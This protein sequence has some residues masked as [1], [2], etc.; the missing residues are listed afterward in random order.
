MA[1]SYLNNQNISNNIISRKKNYKYKEKHNF[2]N[3]DI[4]DSYSSCDNDINETIDNRINDSFS[5]SGI[6]E[7]PQQNKVIDHLKKFK[8]EKKN[9][10][11]NNKGNNNKI[12]RFKKQP[13]NKPK[14]INLTVK[15][16]NFNRK[17]SGKIVSLPRKT[18]QVLSGIKKIPDS[19][20]YNRSISGDKVASRYTQSRFS[21]YSE[22]NQ[23]NFN[24]KI[25]IPGFAMHNSLLNRSINNKN[26][27]VNHYSPIH[28]AKVVKLKGIENEKN[29]EIINIPNKKFYNSKGNNNFISLNNFYGNTNTN[30]NPHSRNKISVVNKSNNT[31]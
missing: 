4:N 3:K 22:N 20:G 19:L 5:F 16:N 10:L 11:N 28:T 2:F 18:N 7:I 27:T 14:N 12:I 13:T 24:N 23:F 6:E 31:K 26:N 17:N 9:N 1:S 21:S 30:I 15:N 25:E 8:K 29:I